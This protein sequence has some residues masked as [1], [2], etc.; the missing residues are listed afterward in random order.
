MIFIRLFY[1]TYRAIR[2][3][4]IKRIG[5]LISLLL[6]KIS[7]ATVGHDCKIYGI[8]RITVSRMD[9][10]LKIGNHFRMNSGRLFNEIGRY[11]PCVLVVGP[12]AVLKIGDNVGVSSVAIIC[13][14]E[15]VIGNNVRIGGNTVIY[16]SDF[17]S[18]DHVKRT[19]QPED[20]SDAKKARVE[21]QDNVFIGAHATILKG[22]VIGRNSIVG[23][24]SVVVKSI[25]ENEVW[26]GNPAVFIKRVN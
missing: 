1:I 23:A 14:L 20:L 12:R 22:V 17:H 8:P 19:S 15:I 5:S 25:P 4:F 26:A 3:R 7:K 24:C 13:Q 16:D 6:L 11:Q 21:I 10:V 2:I 9:A 18:I